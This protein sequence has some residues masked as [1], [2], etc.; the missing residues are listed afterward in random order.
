MLRDA[1]HNF[2][3]GIPTWSR[4]DCLKQCLASILLGRLLPREICVVD[5]GGRFDEAVFRGTLDCRVRVVKPLYNLGIAGSWNLIHSLYAPQ[6][7]VYARDDVVFG[8]EALQSLMSCS[9]D[10][11]PAI[12]DQ[13]WSCF[14]QRER[15]WLK[16][17]EYDDGFW[18]AYFENNDY[19]RRLA[20]ANIERSHAQPADTATFGEQGEWTGVS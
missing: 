6:D 15:V 19:A 16:V 18:P 8:P 3:V 4:Y 20:L 13:A 7:V 10:F 14:L 2:V 17:G 12:A 5:N 9:G 1:T 11:A